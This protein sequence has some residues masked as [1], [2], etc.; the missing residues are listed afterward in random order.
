MLEADI[1][2]RAVRA[3]LEE[4]LG[5][6]DITSRLVL[7]P[8]TTARGIVVAR[9]PITI[10]GLPVAKE[11]FLQVDSALV[12]EPGCEDG[13]ERAAGA[14]LATV[15]GSARSILT[16]ERTA[17]NFLQRLAG[18][19]TATRRALALAGA[20]RVQIS[21]TRKTVPGLRALDRYAVR[22]GGGTNHRAGLFDAILIKDN[23]WRLAGG[24][25]V[26]VRRARLGRGRNDP[27]EGSVEVEATTVEEVEEAIQAGADAVLLDNMDRPTLQRAVSAGRGRAFLEVSGGVREED[28]PFLASLGVDRISLGSLTHSVRAA[29]LALEV[30]P[31]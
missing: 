25:G 17:L 21:E 11:V 1:V 23:H 8:Q 18:I 20:A 31:G 13:D 7:D 12:F 4:D 26:A 28:I 14:R 9:E 24:V 27:I 10:A 19:A 29:D 3:A 22:V 15:R 5:P 30:E 6:G 2:R 16:A